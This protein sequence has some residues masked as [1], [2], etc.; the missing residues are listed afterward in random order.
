MQLDPDITY[1]FGDQLDPL[2]QKYGNNYNQLLD[3][4]SRAVLS[5]FNT[6]GTF[7]PDHQRMLREFI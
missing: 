7:T 1:L 5:R 3:E 6:N 4:Y 2:S